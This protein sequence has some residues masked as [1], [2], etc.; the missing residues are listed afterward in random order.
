MAYEK[1]FLLSLYRNMVLIRKFEERIKYLFLEGIMPGTIHQYQGQEGIAVGICSALEAGDVITSTHRPHGHALARGLSAESIL[2]E[3]FGK[4]T[5]CC[6]GKGGSMHVGDMEKGMAP[7]IAIVAGAVPMATGMAL[8]FK[9]KKEPYAVV[10]FM[11]DGAVNE[12][13]FHEGVNM[14]AVWG[15]PVVYV[16]ENNLYAASTPTFDMVRVKKLSDRAACYGIPGVTIDG[17]DVVKVFET[18]KEALGRAR[19]GE[20]PTLVECMTYRITGH[21]RRDPCNYQPEEERKNALL[22][23]PIVRLRDHLLS[24]G[25]A[26]DAELDAIGHDVDAE[27]EAAVKSA[28]AAPD[29]AP[30][31]ALNDLY[32]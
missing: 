7:A 10:C 26:A 9:M 23:E 17:N 3:L 5:G 28:M 21:S 16:I 19:K 12:G 32:V 30:E 27:I 14:G 1:D 29:P 4:T 31:D 8:A 18:A 11:G 13:A 22:R 2:H 15:L 6:H 24:G 25:L 20:G